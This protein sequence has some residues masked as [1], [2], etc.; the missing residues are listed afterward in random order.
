MPG[1]SHPLK[2]RRPKHPHPETSLGRVREVAVA[3]TAQHQSSGLHDNRAYQSRDR[4][5]QRPIRPAP[6]VHNGPHGSPAQANFP[7]QDAPV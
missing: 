1:L 3:N 6:S 5:I 7:R 2:R 4:A